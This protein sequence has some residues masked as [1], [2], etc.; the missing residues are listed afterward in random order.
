M[1]PLPLT[2]MSLKAKNMDRQLT[3]SESTLSSAFE[4]S[5]I[6]MTLVSPEGKFLKANKAL[7]KMI[8]YSEE[9]ILSISFQT[10]THPDYLFPDLEL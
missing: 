8:G 10:I 3:L 7:S 2:L 5:A 9:E 6:G 4:N 1:V